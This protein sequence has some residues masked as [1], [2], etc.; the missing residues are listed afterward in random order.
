M[1]SREYAGFAEAGGVKNVV[2]SLAEAAADY[3][4]SVTVF[5]PRYGNNTEALDNCTAELHIQVGDTVHSV[6]YFELVRSNIRF[7]FIDSAIFA[8]KKDIYTYCAE[9]LDYFREKLRRPDLKKGDGYIDSHEMNVLF[10][11]AVYCYG[12]RRH[13][14]PLV[15][16]S[17]PFIMQ[18]TATAKPF[19]HLN[20]PHS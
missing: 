17:S 3:G 18:E 7:I 4:L 16:R 14:A 12:L 2:K 1:V 8:E 13:T 6:R 10:Q 9:E 19:I 15:L 11:K 20:M 5:L